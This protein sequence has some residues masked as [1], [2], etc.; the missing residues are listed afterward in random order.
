MSFSL[1]VS[2]TLGPYFGLRDG[3]H[4]GPSYVIPLVE[5]KEKDELDSGGLQGLGHVVDFVPSFFYLYMTLL[6]ILS[7]RNEVV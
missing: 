1:R 4:Q 6:S 2:G 5:R 3:H 7:L